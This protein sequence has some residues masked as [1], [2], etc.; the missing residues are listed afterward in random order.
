MGN[1]EPIEGIGIIG[2]ACRFPGAE[3]VEE[4]WHNLY[5]GVESLTFFTGKES[6]AGYVAAKAVLDHIEMF[7]A[8][9]FGCTPRE[10]ETMDPQHRLFMECSWEALE[11]SGYDPGLYPGR[12]GVYGGAGFNTYLLF[13]LARNDDFSS[14]ADGFRLVIGNDKDHITTRVSYKFDLR[15]PSVGINTACSTSLAAVQLAC[16]GLLNYQCDIALAGGV[17][18]IVPQKSGY[19]HQEGDIHSADGHCRPFDARA[20][21]MVDGSG[22]G[23]VV[24]KRLDE[25]LADGDCIHA[26]IKGSAMNNDGSL[27][28][29]YASPGI[30][31]QA[32]VIAEAQDMA[33]VNPDTITY[34]ETHGTGTAL[35]DPIEIAALTKVFRAG[36]DRKGFCAIG[37][38]KSNFGHLD[39]AAG[40]AGLIKTALSLK[41]RMIPPSL[42][43][44]NPNPAIDFTGSPFYVNNKL[45]KWESPNGPLR[46]GVSSF[47]IGGTNIHV[48]LEEAP[49]IESTTGP[50]PVQ[51]LLLSARTSSAL[52]KATAN[53]AQHLKDNP[54]VNLA[55]V[56]YTLQ[57]GRRAFSHRRMLVCS[58]SDGAREALETMDPGRVFTKDCELG[59]RPVVFMFPGQGTQYV[60]M[61]SGLYRW[62][63]LFRE[64]VDLCSEILEPIL[65]I[66]LRRLLSGGP[67]IAEKEKICDP[68]E[69]KIR[70]YE[71]F[72]DEGRGEPCV[73]PKSYQ[74]FPGEG[75]GEPC[76]HPKSSDRADGETPGPEINQT[77]VTQPAIFVVEYAM[78]KVWMEW[79]VYP[80][81]MIGHSIGEYTAACLAGVFSLQDALRLV[82]AR[83]QLIREI[84]GGGMLSVFLAEKEILPYLTKGLSLAAVNGPSSCV[85]S[86]T[87]KAIETLMQGLAEPG[88]GCRRLQ[89]SHAFHSEMMDPVLERFKEKVAE[90]AVN[91][92]RIPYISNVTGTWITGDEVKDPAYWARHLRHTVRFE[93]G[94]Q[95]LFKEPSQIL[96]EVG[97]GRTLAALAKRHPDKSNQQV[98]LTSIP[99]PEENQS[100]PAFL[101][102]TLG[103]LWLEGV[104]IDWT[105][106]Y[107]QKK[108][109]RL[110][111]PTYPFER[112][113]Y[114][115]EPL[116]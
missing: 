107:R 68:G 24:L 91:T 55:D 74:V 116:P 43:F 77:E 32:E 7:D 41:H 86:G 85:V 28:V 2:M 53:V 105:R 25:A 19:Y 33:G 36:T 76:V 89:T 103:K 51:L 37:S 23:I 46:A 50:G 39:T 10:A 95:V 47:G 18:V 79:G 98:V 14:P 5:H 64:Q 88:V 1:E 97:P 54:Q 17:T 9:F 84:P 113:R 93:E 61:A 111:L 96:L 59:K 110:P 56:G 11:N 13:N 63:P 87:I 72:R 102:T 82:A 16:Q 100:D 34:I 65:G 29:G 12:I 99:H 6:E 44:E 8:S 40:V 22:A 101:M 73:H 58:S 62:E 69:Y 38:V 49:K 15:G 3:N 67:K 71:G 80:K 20:S 26:V 94:M 70:P 45:S 30:D 90:V 42:H 112:Q 83:G 81:A 52:D 104:R 78:A 66:D 4:Y 27:K 48:V 108:R 114:W 75:R 115:I 31:G 109:H 92:P 60:N 106:F 57:T 35:G 21:G